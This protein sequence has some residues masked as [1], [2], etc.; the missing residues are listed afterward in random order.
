MKSKL[1][2]VIVIIF[3]S[4][5]FITKTPEDKYREKMENATNEE[6]MNEIIGKPLM[7]EVTNYDYNY[8]SNFNSEE[9]EF[10]NGTDNKVHFYYARRQTGGLPPSKEEGDQLGYE[11]LGLKSGAVISVIFTDNSVY[12]EKFGRLNGSYDLGKY[13]NTNG[14]MNLRFGEQYTLYNPN[15]PTSL[16]GSSFIQISP[17]DQ[18]RNNP[19]RRCEYMGITLYHTSQLDGRKVSVHY[20]LK[21]LTRPGYFHTESNP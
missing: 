9:T 14:T 3:A 4:C 16:S 2:L 10:D 20:Y 15:G 19:V 18:L 8:A 6:L 5:K 1:T 21:S 12:L 13:A 11:I 7:Y 17:L